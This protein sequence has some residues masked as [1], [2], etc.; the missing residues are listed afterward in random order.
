VVS[1]SGGLISEETNA[2][3]QAFLW[4]PE[5]CK[6]VKGVVVGMHNMIE[7]GMLENENFRKKLTELGLAEVWVTPV[8]EFPFDFHK[9]APKHFQTMMDALA[10][11]SGYTELSKAPIFRS[12]TPPWRL[13]LGILVRGILPELWQSFLFMAIPPNQPDRI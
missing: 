4:I 12:D 9:D 2:N 5:N 8:L 3:P 7:E 6:E 11:V 1:S 13:T 10:K